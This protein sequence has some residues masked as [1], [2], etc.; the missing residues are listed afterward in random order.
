MSDLDSDLLYDTVPPYQL[1]LVDLGVVMELL[2][3]DGG[4]VDTAN[5]DH[6]ERDGWAAGTG[7]NGAPPFGTMERIDPFSPD[8]D[9]NWATNRHI[10]INGRD[11]QTDL[12]TA[13]AVMINENTLIRALEDE[14]PQ[15][16]QL[17]EQ[18]TVTIAV[19]TGVVVGEGLPQVILARVDEAAGGGGAALEAADQAAALFGAQVEGLPNYTLSLDTSELAPGTYQLWISMGNGVFHH[20]LIELVEE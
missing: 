20:L 19:P 12:L 16:A 18:I 1:E 15:V 13:T 14:T 17:G 4:V 10:I 5:A 9:D 3:A 7:P 6:P 8:L 11:A 2:D